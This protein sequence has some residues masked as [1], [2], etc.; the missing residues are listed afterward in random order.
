MA[1][2]ASSTVAT[3]M[4]LPPAT[5]LPTTAQEVGGPTVYVMMDKDTNTSS[6]AKK[7]AKGLSIAQIT[8]GVISMLSQIILICLHEAYPGSYERIAGAGE[9]IYCGVFF[10][11]AGCIGL[12][13]SRKPSTCN[14]SAF[15]TLSILASLFSAAQI[16]L[17]SFNLLGVATSRSYYYGYHRTTYPSSVSGAKIGL[18]G[19][20]ILAAL[21]E[22]VIAIISSAVC[23]RGCCC[24]GGPSSGQVVYLSQGATAPSAPQVPV[25]LGFMPQP[26][27][28]IGHQATV[29]QNLSQLPSYGDVVQE[30]LEVKE[31]QKSGSAGYVRF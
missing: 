21:A 28:V 5:Q 9:G 24:T 1:G 25:Q 17:A 8:L 29:G 6:F 2:L 16:I 19:A 7:T 13:A 27:P 14:I 3:T 4:Q 22:G 26:V 10:V 12:L 30:Q 11:I 31:P 23:C 20:M 18:F 15:L